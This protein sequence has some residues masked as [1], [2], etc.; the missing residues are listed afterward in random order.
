VATAAFPSVI[1]GVMTFTA[2]ALPTVRVVRG[3]DFSNDPSDV[4]MIG[5]QNIDAGGRESAGSF[6]QSMQTFGG[7]REESGTVNGLVMSRNGQADQDLACTTAFGYLAALE[8]AV[9]AD[10]TLGLTGFD[11]VVA[12]MQ[13]GDVEESQ[14]DEGAETVLAFTISYKIRI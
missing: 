8:A 3:R 1:A 2:A 13:S 4:V 12:E 6:Q 11:Y 14:N 7:A 9:R 10:K 5:A